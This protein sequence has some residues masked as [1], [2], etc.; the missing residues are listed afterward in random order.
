MND[1]ASRKRPGSGPQRQWRRPIPEEHIN[2]YPLPIAAAVAATAAALLGFVIS[3]AIVMGIWLFA[4]HGNESTIQVM[5]AAGIAWQGMHLVPVTIAGTTI[6]LLPWG[7]MAIPVT[8]L[9][10]STQWAF[11]SAQPK[12]G[13]QFWRISIFISLIYAVLS[14]VIKLVTSTK[15]L[16]TSLISSATHT[17]LLA[18]LVTVS[19]LVS[20]APSRSILTDGMSDVV[21]QGI[22]P[23]LIAF[24]VLMSLGALATT[25]SMIVHWDEIK[26]VTILMAPGIFN[27][28]FLT[29]LCIG[30]LPT[31]TVW[32]MSYLLGPGV[33]LG[34]SGH[35][36]ATVAEPG[37]LPA[38]PLLS[39]LPSSV[40]TASA[41]LIVIPIA[42]GVMMYFLIPRERWQAQGDTFALAMSYVVR[43]KEFLTLLV[44]IGILA[45]LSWIAAAAA[46]GSLGI[47]YLK[48]VGP[49][50]NAVAWAAISICGLSAL[51]TLLLP[52]VVLSLIHWWSHR[53]TSKIE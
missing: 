20:Y 49:S 15:D 5:R 31:A 22:R 17:F 8:L 42:V 52:R 43:G 48:F 29:L 12:T 23:G 11:K 38:F 16:N 53:E 19:C 9:W 50:P 24:G 30:Y 7:F 13:P 32:S 21:V 39:I 33:Q 18:I 14:V 2:Q 10:R 27:G 26:A 40:S 44:S 51:L 3:F 34:G 25:I 28:L 4:A 1:A 47:G 36:S 35:V 6:G 46:S 41:F 45:A 37:A